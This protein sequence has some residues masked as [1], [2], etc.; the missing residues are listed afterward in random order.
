MVIILVMNNRSYAV[1]TESLNKL[2]NVIC[3]ANFAI[4]FFL[5]ESN[6]EPLNAKQ[7]FGITIASL[8]PIVWGNWLYSELFGSGKSVSY[9]SFILFAFI[10]V[11]ILFLLLVT[12]MVGL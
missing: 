8:G 2:K 5:F 10:A 12:S 11:S 3:V 6:I 4:W 9:R 1:S 7:M